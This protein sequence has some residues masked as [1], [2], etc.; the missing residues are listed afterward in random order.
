VRDHAYG[1]LLTL[2]RGL[3]AGAG[4]LLAGLGSGLYA[5][6][7]WKQHAFG[8]LEIERIAR[9]VLPS[10]VAI[11]LGIEIV[12][13][14]FLLSTFGLKIRPYSAMVEEIERTH[15]SITTSSGDCQYFPK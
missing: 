6:W 8:N 5:V 3:V 7:E 9:I 2:E 11:S 13:F 10:S 4:I 15:A 1:Q 14:S 12:L